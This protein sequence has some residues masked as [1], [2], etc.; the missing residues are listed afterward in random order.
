MSSVGAVGGGG[1]AASGAGAGAAAS[2]GA[3]SSVGA[4]VGASAVGATGGESNGDTSAAE[5]VGGGSESGS[6]VFVNTNISTQDWCQLRTH[7]AEPVQESPEIDL[8]KMLEWL[9]AI[10]LLEAANSQK[11]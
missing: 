8:K 9:M 7:A 2:A 11:Q 1:A 6:N 3:A 4:S 10:K 5:M